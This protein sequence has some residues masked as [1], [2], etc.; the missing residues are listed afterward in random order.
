MEKGENQQQTQPTNGVD[1]RIRTRATLAFYNLRKQ[2]SL[3]TTRR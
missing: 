3:L 2:P 1:A